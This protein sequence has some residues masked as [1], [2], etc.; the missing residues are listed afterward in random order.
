MI[1]KFITAS[2]VLLFFAL[3]FI[4]ND[5]SAQNK[6]AQSSQLFKHFQMKYVFGRKYNDTDAMKDAM[7]SMIALDPSDDS[8]KLSLCYFY[9]EDNKFTQSLFVSADLLSRSPDNLDAL[10]MNA[11][12]LENM[13]L[14]DRAVT[15][16]ES[17][18][19]KTNDITVLYQVAVLMYELERYNECITNCDIIIKNPT[20]KT[21]KLTF[22]KNDKENQDISLEATAYNLK[23]MV[24]K[25]LGNKTEAKAQFD[26]ALK[27]EPEFAIAIQNLADLDK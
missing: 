7:Y 3:V 12:S 11:I 1:T 15:Q 19:L 5:V 17:L 13:G 10:R 23:G 25:E 24:Q 4:S 21:V 2:G 22:A 16:Y 14:R 6:E 9:L 27:I 26:L 18:Y 20:A 8:L